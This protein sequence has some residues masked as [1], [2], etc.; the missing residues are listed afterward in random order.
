MKAYDRKK[1]KFKI[2][3]LTWE[4][5]PKAVECA[6]TM[7]AMKEALLSALAFFP[8]LGDMPRF[9]HPPVHLQNASPERLFSE[10]KL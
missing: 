3:H 10:Q 4:S 2:R 7:L 6:F 8:C 9:T 1:V 5:V